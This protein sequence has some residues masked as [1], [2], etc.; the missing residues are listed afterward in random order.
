MHVQS[1]MAVLAALQGGGQ[2]PAGLVVLH[3]APPTAGESACQA[4]VGTS[5]R[6]R[7][8]FREYRTADGTSLS[9]TG[10]VALRF[11]TSTRAAQIDSLIAAT[12]LEVFTSV[13][14]SACRRFVFAVAQQ[15]TDANAFAQALRQSGLV[16][17]ATPDLA[18]GRSEGIRGDSFYVDL[19]DLT[20]AV[21]RTHALVD[22]APAKFG[23]GQVLTDYVGP[24]LRVSGPGMP[25]QMASVSS[26]ASAVDL[27]KTHGLTTLR[28]D[29]PQRSAPTGV[30]VLIY[31][32]SGTLVRQLVSESLDPGH[33]LVGWDGNDD[34][35]RH[36]QPGVYVAVMTAGSFRETRRLVVR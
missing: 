3:F 11:K 36:V 18:I 28:L 19:S 34:R 29:V 8:L 27:V 32:L 24:L 7:T 22:E 12:G 15:P 23:M 1:L 16:D 2:Q 31:S 35:G 14:R 33:Y 17:Y 20:K 9:I 26:S 5:V 30:R 6:G 10:H 25:A 21:T 13:K 4:D